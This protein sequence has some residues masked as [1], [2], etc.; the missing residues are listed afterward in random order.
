[1]GALV[2]TLAGGILDIGKKALDQISKNY[3]DEGDHVCYWNDWKDR[4]QRARRERTVNSIPLMCYIIL[5][6]RILSKNSM[7]SY[8]AGL[9]GWVWPKIKHTQIL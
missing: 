8:V 9:I 5:F 1:M 3:I 4:D 7:I 6:R 2:N